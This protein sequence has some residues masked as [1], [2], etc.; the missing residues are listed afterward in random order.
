MVLA[1]S[2]Y[3]VQ[4]NFVT[5]SLIALS[6]GMALVSPALVRRGHLPPWAVGVG[7]LAP[8]SASGIALSFF[9]LGDRHA[10]PTYVVPWAIT[11]VCITAWVIALALVSKREVTAQG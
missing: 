2:L 4:D 9:V 6:V 7:R 1:D 11:V 10:A 5:L 8:V 3:W